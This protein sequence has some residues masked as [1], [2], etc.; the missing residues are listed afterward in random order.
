M[1]ERENPVARGHLALTLFQLGERAES[2]KLFRDSVLFPHAGFLRRFLEVFWP[3]RF[4]T[5]LGK[6]AKQEFQVPQKAKALWQTALERLQHFQ[7]DELEPN[8]DARFL[9]QLSDLGW[10]LFTKEGRR[11][12]QIR[13]AGDKLS[14]IAIDEFFKGRRRSALEVFSYAHDVRPL[15]QKIT[16]HLAYLLLLDGRPEEAEKLLEDLIQNAITRFDQDRSEQDLPQPDAI[17]CYAWCRHEQGFH[18]EA[19]KLL[20]A[21]YPEGPED[22]GSHFVAAMS[23]LMLG[24]SDEFRA[25]LSQAL[26]PYFIDTWEQIVRPF[27]ATTLLWLETPESQETSAD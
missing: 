17:V 18:G 7:P 23:W 11:I 24:R 4:E 20:S 21:V 9:A 15:N 2:A 6:P 16:E 8:A 27:I 25:A 14:A 22:Y 19:I 10:R 1:V 13:T 3:L 26:G 5:S 12:N